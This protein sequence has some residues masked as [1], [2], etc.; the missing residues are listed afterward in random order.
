MRNL[1]DVPAFPAAAADKGVGKREGVGVGVG[2]TERKKDREKETLSF[3]CNES[4]MQRKLA[5]Q[6]R[7]NFLRLNSCKAHFHSPYLD[8][9]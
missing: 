5:G 3:I 6:T 9:A 2:T 8:L 1:P 4:I 7:K